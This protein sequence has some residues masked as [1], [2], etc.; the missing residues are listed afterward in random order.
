[1]DSVIFYR[2]SSG[3]G[4]SQDVMESCFKVKHYDSGGCVLKRRSGILFRAAFMSDR[5]SL[6][7]H[8][9]SHHGVGNFHEA[10]D[11]GALHVVDIAVR[12]GAVLDALLVDFTHDSVEFLVNFFR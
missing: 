3:Q 2:S 11:I 12:F 8:T 5:Y 1:M 10:G 6:S 7:D 4:V 9:L